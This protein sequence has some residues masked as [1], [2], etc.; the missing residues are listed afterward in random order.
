MRKQLLLVTAAAEIPVV[1]VAALLALLLAPAAAHPERV[2]TQV[3]ICNVTAHGAAQVA[4]TIRNDD[5]YEH[6]YEVLLTVT[7]GTTPLGTSLNYGNWVQPGKTATV[8]AL[9]PLAQ[10]APQ[11]TCA[12]RAY[13]HDTHI[14]HRRGGNER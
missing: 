4:F 9:I 3:Q 13:V 11:A 6:N 2:S 1:L 14:G 12:A 7:D 8:R 5:A 10:P